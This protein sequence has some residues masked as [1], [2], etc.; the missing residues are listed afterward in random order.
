MR[1]C[2]ILFSIFLF[3]SCDRYTTEEFTPIKIDFENIDWYAKRAQLAYQTDTEIKQSLTNVIHTETLPEL[4]IQY[5]IEQLPDNRQ[6]ISVRGTANLANVREDLEYT[7]S[8]NDKIHIYVHKGF[9]E[10]TKA[11]F[12]SALPHLDKNQEI[13]AT[14][15]SLGAAVSTLLMVYL[16][17][18]GFNVGPSVNFGQPKF[19]NKKGAEKYSFL[20]LTRVVNDKDLVPL[21]PPVTLLSSIHGEYRHLGQEV[22]LLGGPHF[23]Y[24]DSHIVTEKDL[25]EPWANLGDLSIK[26]HMIAN[27]RIAIQN[28]AT[29]QVEVPYKDRHEFH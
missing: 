4:D 22:I 29:K 6:L 14:G 18:E 27:Y 5:F 26:E 8:R 23:V 19:T 17:H 11:V 2:L 15:H 9:D 3:S 7:K 25:S 10:D 20:P 21:V 12:D 13:L 24:L 1:T 28:K 16:H